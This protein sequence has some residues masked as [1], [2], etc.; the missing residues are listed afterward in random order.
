MHSVASMMM[1]DD[2]EEKAAVIEMK[3]DDTV[4]IDDNH[5]NGGNYKRAMFDDYEEMKMESDFKLKKFEKVNAKGWHCKNNDPKN[6]A[7]N[8]CDNYDPAFLKSCSDNNVITTTTPTGKKSDKGTTIGS[9]RSRGKATKKL[10]S[11]SNSNPYEF[12]YYSGFGPCWGKR[13]GGG[14]RDSGNK[15]SREGREV[16]DCTIID[17]LAPQ[18]TTPSSSSS[19]IEDNHQEFDYVDEYDDEEEDDDDE[20]GDCGKKRMRKPVKAR[21][22]KSLM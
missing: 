21:S 17:T 5:E 6:I 15:N 22:L 11:S 13:R 14:D 4:I 16:G 7:Q 3:V 12:Y 1:E 8:M 18:N 20:D 19:P 9:R 10:G 2:V